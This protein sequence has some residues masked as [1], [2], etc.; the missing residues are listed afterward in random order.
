MKSQLQEEMLVV[1]MCL[2]L[3]LQMCQVNITHELFAVMVCF[4]M[5]GMV[6]NGGFV[7]PIAVEVVTELQ[8]LIFIHGISCYYWCGIRSTG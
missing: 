3:A 1:P 2:E 8:V 6:S 7:I 5:A 4:E